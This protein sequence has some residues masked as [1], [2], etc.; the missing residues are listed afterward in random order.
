MKPI[1]AARTAVLVVD[2]Q[3]DYCNPQ[4]AVA[5]SQDFGLM[6]PILAPQMRLLEAAVGAGLLVVFV[7]ATILPGHVDE[8]PAR[9][10]SKSSTLAKYAIPTRDYVI[11]GTWGHD[12]VDE[13][14]RFAPD[15]VH[16]FKSRNGAFVNTNLDLILRSNGVDT[17]LVTG[18]ATD[19]C[20]AATVRG[21]E[22]HGYR[23]IVLRDC[24]S[25]FKPENHE[26]TLKVLA[27]RMEV[28]PS[29]DV[30]PLLG[31][32]EAVTSSKRTGAEISRGATG[33]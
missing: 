22:D 16:V 10:R 12:V 19:G 29:A 21:A 9:L 20:V 7:R 18:M 15:A 2:V 3:N 4:G 33:S 14:K 5:S 1:E 8:S 28:V 25:S 30:L 23:C 11:A 27:S 6:E 26:H 31:P 17:V 13:L 32:S 24:V